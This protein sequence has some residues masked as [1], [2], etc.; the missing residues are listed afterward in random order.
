M[1][2]LFVAVSGIIAFLTWLGL[3]AQQCAESMAACPLVH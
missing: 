3:A 1:K 2:I